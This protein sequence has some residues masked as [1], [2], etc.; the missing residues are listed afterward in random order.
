MLI[1]QEKKLNGHQCTEI[2]EGPA[3]GAAFRFFAKVATG[4]RQ[5]CDQGSDRRLMPRAGRRSK[6]AL[7]FLKG[8]DRLR[9]FPQNSLCPRWLKN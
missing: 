5:F 3:A 7:I 6:T 1:Q 4:S 9:P 8:R 2:F